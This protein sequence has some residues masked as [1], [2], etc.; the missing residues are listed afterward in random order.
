VIWRPRN[1]LYSR[2]VQ[3]IYLGPENSFWAPGS[4]GRLLAE[5]RRHPLPELWF[6]ARHHR[7]FHYHP[8]LPEVPR[9]RRGAWRRD[10][11]TMPT[12][13]QAP[14]EILIKLV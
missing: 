1:I 12:Q 8:V 4:Q 13:A 14:L 5:G 7:A 9:L 10:D 11:G 2:F 3:K 6:I